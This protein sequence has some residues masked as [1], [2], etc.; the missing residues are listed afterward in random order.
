MGR[1]YPEIETKLA[2]FI[3]RQHMFFVATAPDGSNGHARAII[4]IDVERVADACGYGIPVM[5]FKS[6]RESHFRWADHLGPNG[7]KAYKEEN[8]LESIDG[9]AALSCAE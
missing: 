7:L 2:D 8:N 3:Q 9:L 1:V 5:D 6:D 4:T